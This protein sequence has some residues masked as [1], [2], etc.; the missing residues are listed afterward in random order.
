M[1]SYITKEV[2]IR[3]RFDFHGTILIS[4]CFITRLT[5]S[6]CSKSA[7]C[8]YSYVYN[9][10]HFHLLCA[11][12]KVRYITHSLRST[13]R[14]RLTPVAASL[15]LVIQLNVATVHHTHLCKIDRNTKK[16]SSKN[17]WSTWTG[18]SYGVQ[19]YS[20]W[21]WVGPA[22]GLRAKKFKNWSHGTKKFC[23]KT[24]LHKVS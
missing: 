7:S 24:S 17:T 2:K 13:T 23:L 5:F 11:W 14:N 8:H 4:T 6:R 10:M 16:L 15:L 3:Q 18:Q 21:V 19:W 20:M 1:I 12:D 22:L 9:W